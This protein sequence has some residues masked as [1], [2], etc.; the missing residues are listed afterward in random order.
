[1][2]SRLFGAVCATLITI[3]FNANAVVIDFEGVTTSITTETYSIRTFNGYDIFVPH[4]HYEDA[5]YRVL[6]GT[7]YLTVDH[8]SAMVNLG[9]DLS[10]NNGR[11][12]SLHSIEVS[13]WTGDG[14]TI[15]TVTG[16]IIGGG[17]IS[18]TFTMDRLSGF[19]TFVFGSG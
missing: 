8:I 9:F 3:S 11:A 15:L 13:E 6:R 14:N 5:S 12:F 17:N 16:Q 10:A 2:K 4:G 18:T 7:D 1:M 19:E